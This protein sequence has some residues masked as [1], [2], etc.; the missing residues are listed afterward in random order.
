[1]VIA[2]CQQSSAQVFSNEMSSLDKINVYKV[3]TFEEFV[4]RF[5]NDPKSNIRKAYKYYHI[6][7]KIKRP[8]LIKS[9][10]DYETKTWDT[11]EINRFTTEALEAKSTK[12][13]NE[14][15][16]LLAEVK[17]SFRYN[18][19]DVEI[20]LMLWYISD[21]AGA[22]KWII[23]GIGIHSLALNDF[24]VPNLENSKA[25]RFI[26]PVNNEI[27]FTELVKVFE[28]RENLPEYFEKDFFL[29]KRSIAFYNAVLQNQL[30]FLRVKDVQYH[31]LQYDNWFLP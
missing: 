14:S 1:M 5:N 30:R 20:P 8:A 19:A 16:S 15:A 28:D 17:C 22:S 7:F 11:A 18:S 12:L 2:F 6:D 3:V 29:K 21:A 9:L 27:N 25:V 13:L 31:D 4:N 26:N 10:F 24:S 23:C